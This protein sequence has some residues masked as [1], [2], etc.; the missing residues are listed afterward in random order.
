MA[1]YFRVAA[2]DEIPEGQGRC[3]TVAGRRVAVFRVDDRFY[4]IDDRC[5]HAEASLSEGVVRDCQVECPRHGATFDLR[6]G[7]ATALPATVPV[8]TYQVRV[9]GDDVLVA[10]D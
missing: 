3:F 5:T 9:E 6:S 1:H 4:A 8:R 10:V 7:E 2:R